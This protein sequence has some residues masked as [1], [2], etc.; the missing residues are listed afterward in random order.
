M[1][2]FD[3][4]MVRARRDR[5][6][7]PLA[8]AD[9]LVRAPATSI[10]DR[11]EDVNRRFPRALDLGCHGG[12]VASAIRGLKGVEWIACCDLSPGFA[13]R[14]A[15]TVGAAALA[16]D[17]ELLP[18][19]DAAFDLIVSGLSLHWVND[20]PGALIQIRRSLVPDGLFLGSMLG[21]ET[22]TELRQ[23]WLRAEA[24]IEGGAGPRVSP[25]ADVRDAAGLLQRAGFALPVADVDELTVTYEDPIRLMRDLRAMGEMQI[26][27][28]C[29]A[30]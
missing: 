23:A 26:V 13:A 29:D 5:A 27:V 11:L 2:V 28:D 19:A 24:E 6:A 14:S 4:R 25:F 21:G 12:E 7:P 3:R 17:E 18:F 22:L 9:L 20:L 8:E 1:S 16:A 15:D 30:L 10:A